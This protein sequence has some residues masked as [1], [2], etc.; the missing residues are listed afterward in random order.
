M[1]KKAVSTQH[2]VF[3]EQD[4]QASICVLLGV[5]DLCLCVKCGPLLMML[6]QGSCFPRCGVAPSYCHDPN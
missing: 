6:T 5:Y 2:M 1:Q 4:P 3:P